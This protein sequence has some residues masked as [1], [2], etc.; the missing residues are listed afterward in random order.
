MRAAIGKPDAD[1]SERRRETR[2]S[3][4][5]RREKITLTSHPE[6]FV[7]TVAAF[8]AMEDETKGIR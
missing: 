3:R 7:Y 6:V 1:R 2:Q 5:K 4:P 8:L